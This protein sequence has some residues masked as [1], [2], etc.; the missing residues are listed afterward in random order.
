[1]DEIRLIIGPA[2]YANPGIDQKWTREGTE[3]GHGESGGEA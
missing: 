1:M 2:I 3:A